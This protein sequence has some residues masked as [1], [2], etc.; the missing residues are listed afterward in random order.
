MK[1]TSVH[2]RILSVPYI[3]PDRW[4]GGANAGITTVLV[5]VETDQG[6]AGIGEANGDRSAAAVAA[7]IDAMAP[8]VVGREPFAIEAIQADIFRRGKWHNVRPFANQAIVGIE[9]ALWDIIGKVAG[10]PIAN[11][12][13][14]RIRDSVDFF[15]YLQRNELPR[16]LEEARRAVSVGYEVIYLKVGLDERDDL[17]LAAAVRDAVG[18]GPRIRVDPNEAWTPGQAVRM[19]RALEPSG[20]DFLEQPVASRD[21]DGLARVRFASPIPIAANQAAFTHFDVLEVIKRNAADVIVTGPYQAGGLLQFKKIAALAEMACL[22][23]N[24]HAVGELGVGAVAGLHVCSTIPNLTDGNQT[25]HQLLADDILVAPVLH[26]QRGKVD[27]PTGPGLG[28]ELD[29]DKVE[30][31]ADLYSRHGQYFNF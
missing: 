6:V 8:L 17:A 1:I 29:W 14:G 19:A 30:R 25:H 18:D 27:V 13:G 16:M 12:M 21:L 5:I 11:L 3:E 23:I 7:A 20:I 26:F 24:R 10:Q 15:W 2:T 4:S 31:F 22:P 9:I 28:I